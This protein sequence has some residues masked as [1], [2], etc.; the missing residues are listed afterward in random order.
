MLRTI[1]PF[2]WL[3]KSANN[4]YN[5]KPQKPRSGTCI[6]AALGPKNGCVFCL[7]AGGDYTIFMTSVINDQCSFHMQYIV[8]TV[9]QTNHW[10]FSTITSSTFIELPANQ[11]VPRRQKLLYHAL[12]THQT[13]DFLSMKDLSQYSQLYTNFAIQG[14]PSCTIMNGIYIYIL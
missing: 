4:L 2:C 6:N 10:Q 11:S 5:H 3:L 8:L 12:S 7:K 1:L 13:V 14:A 9:V